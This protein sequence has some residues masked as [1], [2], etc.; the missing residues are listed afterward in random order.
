[1]LLLIISICAASY[2][3]ILS[4]FKKIE[5]EISF[6]SMTHISEV[7]KQTALDLESKSSDWAIWD[8]LYNFMDTND[9]AFVD[10]NISLDSLMKLNL[11]FMVF[12]KKRSE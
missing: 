9:K 5:Q 10:E 3:F 4:N 6:K 1:M 12:I 8:S 2:L 7:I 11:D